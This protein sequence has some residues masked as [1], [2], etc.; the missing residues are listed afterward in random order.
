M[1]NLGFSSLVET[2]GAFSS[3]TEVVTGTAAT[4]KNLKVDLPKESPDGK[5]RVELKPP[6][7][8]DE[9]QVDSFEIA[10]P[11]QPEADKVADVADSFES[12][13]QKCERLKCQMRDL[14][15]L[16]K[17]ILTR[18]EA[19]LEN[20]G[21]DVSNFLEEIE[22]LFDKLTVASLRKAGEECQ[23][24][25]KE[26]KSLTVTTTKEVEARLETPHKKEEPSSPG[27]RESPEKNLLV[28]GAFRKPPV[29]TF[30][31]STRKAIQKIY[32][33]N[34][35]KAWQTWGS[36]SHKLLYLTPS[37]CPAWKNN[38]DSFSAIEEQLYSRI[39]EMCSLQMSIEKALALRFR[40]LS[41]TWEILDKVPEKP[42]SNKV[43]LKP[44]SGR[45]RNG[46][47]Q[48]DSLELALKFSISGIV[49]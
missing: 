2:N 33:Q 22:D 5:G 28:D 3:I 1:S 16:E 48:K 30:V 31:F 43:I 36:T 9:K 12:A 11:A 6:S 23:P 14:L 21:V 17:K 13:E 18:C 26:D 27:D 42:L 29:A 49:A 37:M 39:T 4:Y 34:R 24:L 41:E 38:K 20:Q 45:G 35:Q 40:A 7:T 44:G 25:L 46:Y 15:L 19:D 32:L 8:S 47:Q 10:L